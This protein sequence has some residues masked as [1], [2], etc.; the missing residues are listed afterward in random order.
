MGVA[1]AEVVI[2]Y[3]ETKLENIY[4]EGIKFANI[5]NNFLILDS[6]GAKYQSLK[7]RWTKYWLKIPE[8][9]ITLNKEKHIFLPDGLTLQKKRIYDTRTSGPN[10]LLKVIKYTKPELKKTILV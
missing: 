2:L 6:T 3:L 5:S 9:K 10:Q 4:T 1:G 8:K 7:K